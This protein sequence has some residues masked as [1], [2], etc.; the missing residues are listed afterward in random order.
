VLYDYVK[1]NPDTDVAA[2]F[3]TGEQYGFGVRKG[4]SALRKQIDEALKK[5]KSDGTYDKIYK[6]WFGTAPEK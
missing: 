4:N 2:E 3:D 5:A 6:K 1:D